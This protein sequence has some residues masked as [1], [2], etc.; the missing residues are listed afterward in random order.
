MIWRQR[1]QNNMAFNH[2]P[3]MPQ[4]KTAR[5]AEID[6]EIAAGVNVAQQKPIKVLRHSRDVYPNWTEPKPRPI[7]GNGRMRQISLE[8][9]LQA[10][11]RPMC[12]RDL[13]GKLRCSDDSMGNTLRKFHAHIIRTG[14]GRRDSPYM[15]ARKA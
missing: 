15:Y 11:D 9:L 13:A 5:E 14:F 7:G 3:L 10:L 1:G 12:R 2:D 4:V 6:Q 8:D